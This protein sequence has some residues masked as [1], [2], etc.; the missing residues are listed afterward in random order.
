LRA[1]IDNSKTSS[2]LSLWLDAVNLWLSRY[3]TLPVWTFKMDDL[4]EYFMQRMARDSCGIAG[5]RA[6]QTATLFLLR[7][8]YSFPP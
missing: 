5:M 7:F 3:N 6:G 8:V 4:A 2:L 1:F